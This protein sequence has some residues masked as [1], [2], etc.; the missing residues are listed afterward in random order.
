MSVAPSVIQAHS[1]ISKGS[2]VITNYRSGHDAES[3][4]ADYLAQRGYTVLASNWRTRYCEIDI[5]AQKGS[6]VVMVEVKSRRAA[7]QGGGLDYITPKKLQ[8]MQFAAELWVSAHQWR[9]S[10]QLG[11]IAIDAGN[12][13]FIDD[14]YV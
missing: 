2:A 14:I 12:I 8:Q 5:V 9:G 7:G 3:V 1:A 10:Y 13:T 11:A 4:A 6:T